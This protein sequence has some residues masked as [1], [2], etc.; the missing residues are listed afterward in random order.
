MNDNEQ[1]IKNDQEIKNE[2]EKKNDQEIKNDQEK[3]NDQEIKNDQEKKTLNKRY[4]NKNYGFIITRHV[5]SEKTNKYWN[6]SIK[7]IRRLYPLTTIVVIDDNSNQKFVK[8][9]NEYKN[10][11]YIQS[12]FHGRGELLPFIYLLKYH[13]FDKAIIIHDSVFFHKKINFEKIKQPVI[14]LWHF[15][16]YIDETQN[17]INNIRIAS[18]LKN[19]TEVINNLSNILDND[20]NVIQWKKNLEWSGCFG[21]QCFINYYFLLNIQKKYKFTNMIPL[22]RTRNDRCSLE[23]I[24]AVLFYIEF[25]QLQLYK[26]LFGDIFSY[27][28]WGYTFEEY[29][30]NLKKKRV[31][32][33]VVKVWTGR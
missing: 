19:K 23:R 1:I 7:C 6:Q 16:R 15:N 21:V 32:K 3:K 25:P 20:Y 11:I 4:K 29:S 13:F 26:S 17:K 24:M 33:P 5:N 10:V 27:M 14:P 9:F 12:E 18:Q 2:Q 31:I 28:K 8:P 30:S 22:V